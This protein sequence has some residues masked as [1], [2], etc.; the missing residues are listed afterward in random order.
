MFHTYQAWRNGLNKHLRIIPRGHVRQQVR[1]HLGAFLMKQLK[2][3]DLYEDA[4]TTFNEEVGYFKR[5]G[6]ELKPLGKKASKGGL[7]FLAYFQ[8]YLKIE[9][10]WRSWSHAG[11][12]EASRILGIPETHIAR[13]TNHVESFNCRIKGKYFS[14][15]RR[16][17]RL[18]RIDMWVLTMV[19]KVLPSFFQ[20]QQDKITLDDYYER[21]R[22]RGPAK[23][24]IK[25]EDPVDD[26]SDK[27]ILDHLLDDSNCGDDSTNSDNSDNADDLS[28]PDLEFSF[29][30]LITS[31][32]RFV[33][34][35]EGATSPPDSMLT[36]LDETECFLHDLEDTCSI[37]PD[38]CDD[39][40]PGNAVLL[41]HNSF[42][43][44]AT[45][46]KSIENEEA[47]G[48]QR[49]L[50]AE[51]ALALEIH[52]M[53]HITSN[54]DLLESHISPAIRTR[55]FHSSSPILKP[56]AIPCKSAK[57]SIAP[58]ISLSPKLPDDIAPR[59][60]IP[61]ERQRQQRRH[62]AHGFR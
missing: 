44:A 56:L 48:M 18:P 52:Q 2:E 6:R 36:T 61:F 9:S 21:M 28:D 33:P 38:S 53:L 8:D 43:H 60:L 29:G 22:H 42:D 55:L 47:T 59:N 50:V 57:I 37:V 10:F 11:V 4:L 45:R 31:S 5:L 14:A 35:S 23:K 49:L 51:D 25:P 32:P 40:S 7:T 41:R 12:V 3:I 20:A 39:I 58:A 1:R 24:T 15:Y 62:E 34:D 27:D 19:T 13:T 26:L 54:P 46:M 16:S 30:E 17:G